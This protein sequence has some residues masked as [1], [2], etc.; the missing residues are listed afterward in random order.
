MQ[1]PTK[2]LPES[3]VIAKNLSLKTINKLINQIKALD[4]VKKKGKALKGGEGRIVEYKLFG[5]PYFVK[6]KKVL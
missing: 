5:K 4:T 3:L 2:N 1:Y 6:V